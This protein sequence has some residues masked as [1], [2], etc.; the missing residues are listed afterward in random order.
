MSIKQSFFAVVEP[1]PSSQLSQN[2]TNKSYLT[3]LQCSISIILSL[4][5][6]LLDLF[7]RRVLRILSV[8]MI[9]SLCAIYM[10]IVT[11]VH[12]LWVEYAFRNKYIFKCL[13]RE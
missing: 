2:H 5:P 10:S 11:Q 6:I 1:G 8:Y 7:F 3:S 12:S 9:L 4:S 13:R